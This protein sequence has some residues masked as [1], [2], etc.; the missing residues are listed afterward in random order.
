MRVFSQV[1][2]ALDAIQKNRA[3]RKVRGGEM[4]LFF[5]CIGEKARE[6]HKTLV[7]NTKL[8]T[9]FKEYCNPRRKLDI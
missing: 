7:T 5:L 2:R 6:V 9:A 1:R 8:K 3:Q 4:F